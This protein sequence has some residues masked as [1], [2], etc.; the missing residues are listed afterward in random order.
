MQ[1]SPLLRDSGNA[2]APAHQD[3]LFAARAV[4]DVCQRFFDF[5]G[6]LIHSDLDIQVVGID[7]NVLG[8]IPCQIGVAGGERKHAAI[9][10]AIS[11][12]WVNVIITDVTMAA[13]CSMSVSRHASQP[14]RFASLRYR[15]GCH[16]S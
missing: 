15:G 1:P 4:G 13:R 12:G 7:P 11:G 9:R 8:T 14:S 16:R 6:Q 5:A 10:A 3:H 2:I